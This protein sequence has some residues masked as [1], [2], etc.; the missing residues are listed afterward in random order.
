VLVSAAAAAERGGTLADRLLIGAVS[1]AITLAC[2]LLPSISRSG[3]VRALWGVCLLITA[4][5]HAAYFTGASAR[6]GAGRAA[7]LETPAAVAALRNELDAI[8]ARPVAVVAADLAGA[9]SRALSA[10]AARCRPDV[11]AECRRIAATAGAATAR[12][13]A[14]NEELAQARR[15]A[16]LRARVTAMAGGQDVAKAA[17]AVDPVAGVLAGWLGVS[18]GSI[19]TTVSVLSA[20]VV[21]LLA[22]TLWSIALSR[23]SSP[24][25]AVVEQQQAE[26]HQRPPQHES[27]EEEQQP[28]PAASALDDNAVMAASAGALGN[29]LLLA[30]RRER[31]QPRDAPPKQAASF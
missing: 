13:E 15:A 9:R 28:P 29:L 8:Q 22:C 17:A 5:G 1:V 7:H 24:P 25:A 30:R 21:E 2:H 20:I 4:W 23:Q 11:P 19:V 6:A 27:R 12:V 18:A 26:Q 3:L 31:T 14:L 10:D 16:D